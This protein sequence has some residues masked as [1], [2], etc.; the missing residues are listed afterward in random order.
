M[1]EAHGWR[2]GSAA[3]FLELTSEEAAF[4]EVIGESIRPRSFPLNQTHGVAWAG[5]VLLL[6]QL[7]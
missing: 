1:L 6:V 3:E 5:N 4:V 2:V 7:S